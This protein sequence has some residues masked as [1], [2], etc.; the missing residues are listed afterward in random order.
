MFKLKQM[1]KWDADHKWWWFSLVVMALCTQRQSGLVLTDGW[2]FTGIF[3]V[4]LNQLPRPVQLTWIGDGLLAIT[5]EE[6][7]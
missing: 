6:N 1:Q 7:S 2:P 5:K 3:S 4:L